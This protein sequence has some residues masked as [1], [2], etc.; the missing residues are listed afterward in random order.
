M[1]SV[2]MYSSL[3]PTL[4]NYHPNQFTKMNPRNFTHDFHTAKNSGHLSVIAVIVTT[5][6]KPPSA[7]FHNMAFLI[8]ILIHRLN[9]FPF[10]L[11]LL[12]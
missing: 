10:A 3:L 9:V 12:F 5:Y 6:E 1:H 7:I 11:L 2:S 4:I 8:F